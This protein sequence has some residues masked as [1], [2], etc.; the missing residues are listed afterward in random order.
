MGQHMHD[1]WIAGSVNICM[2]FHVVT[3]G[4]SADISD[5]CTAIE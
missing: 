4:T 3:P 5:K 2:Y 1:V